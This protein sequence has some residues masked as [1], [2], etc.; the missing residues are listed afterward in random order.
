MMKKVKIIV[1]TLLVSL[2]LAACSNEQ[3]ESQGLKDWEKITETGKLV[4]GVDDTFVPMGFRDEN[5][6]LVGFDIDL[7]KAVAAELGV[8]AEIQPIDWMMKETELQ[9]GRIDLIWNGYTVTKER[10]EKVA[11][12]QAYLNNEQVIVTLAKNNITSYQNL[13]DKPLGA[14]EGSSGADVLVANP[15]LLLDFVEN[16]EAILYP[17]FVETFL[18]LNNGRIDGFIIDSV[19]AEYYIEQEGQADKYLI[20]DSQFPQEDYAVGVRKGDSETLKQI[21]GALDKLKAAGEMEKISQ[22]WF[23]EDKTIK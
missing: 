9:N 4:I 23:G 16:Q 1:S 15:E 22:K 19:F 18:D 14:Q 2:S 11:F 12:T 3:E 13:K 17:T 20:L 7:A 6:N 10:Q 8:E 21:N 5:D